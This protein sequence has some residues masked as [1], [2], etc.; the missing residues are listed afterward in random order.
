MHNLSS[1]AVFFHDRVHLYPCR[2]TER[3][4]KKYPKWVMLREAWKMP[5]LCYPSSL[6]DHLLFSPPAGRFNVTLPGRLH[7]RIRSADRR[8]RRWASSRQNRMLSGAESLPR[9]DGVWPRLKGVAEASAREFGVRMWQV[10][11]GLNN[12]THLRVLVSF[13]AK[14]VL[15]AP[16]LKIDDLKHK[17][18]ALKLLLYIYLWPI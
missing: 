5:W 2:R 12:L 18:R 11:T 6:P 17:K 14:G 4:T 1:D 7:L 3:I 13:C 8:P 9:S 16:Q 10:L 15:M